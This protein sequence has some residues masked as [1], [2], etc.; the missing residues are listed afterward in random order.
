M[1]ARIVHEVL[2]HGE[3]RLSELP[4]STYTQVHEAASEIDKAPS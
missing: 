4:L 1:L 2:T 3:S